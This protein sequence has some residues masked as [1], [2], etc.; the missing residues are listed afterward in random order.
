[1]IDCPVG[2]GRERQIKRR[3]MLPQEKKLMKNVMT[4]I[5]P[6]MSERRVGEDDNLVPYSRTLHLEG[7]LMFYGLSL[8]ILHHFLM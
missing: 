4:C 8:I 6:V 3:Q 7:N 1:M 5:H 2:Q